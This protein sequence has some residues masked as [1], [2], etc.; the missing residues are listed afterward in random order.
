MSDLAPGFPSDILAAEPKLD[1]ELS[2]LAADPVEFAEIEAADGEGKKLRSFAILAYTGGPMKV[3][4]FFHPVIV[5]LSGVKAN[6]KKIP[7]L[8]HHDATRI[9]GHGEVTVSGNDIHISG[10][11]SAETDAAREVVTSSLNGFP[12]QASIGASP[13]ERL[14]LVREGQTTQVNGKT[15]KGPVLVA[16]KSTLKEVSFVPIGAD[17]KTSAKVAATAPKEQE[18][19]FNAWLQAKGFDP[20]TISEAQKTSLQA[21]YDAEKAGGKPGGSGGGDTAR[22]VNAGGT[23]AFDDIVASA[24]NERERKTKITNLVA[25]AIEDRPDMIDEIEALGSAAIEAKTDPQK[26]ELEMLRA[27]RHT[28]PSNVRATRDGEI[29]AQVIEAAICASAGLKDVDKH[30]NERTLE[31][32]DKHFRHGMGLQQLL[33]L[34][35][36]AHGVVLQSC[37][38]VEG[39]LR[40]AFGKSDI[41]ASGG[42][43][44]FSLSGIL[45]NVANKFV[46]QYFNSVES[47]WRSIAAIRTV[48]DFKQIS[49]YSL[50]GDLQYEE[51]GPTGEIKHGTLGEETYNNQAKSYA[52]MLGISRKD[53]INDDLGAFEQLLRLLGRG[54]ALKIN[55]VF[56]TAFLDNASFFTAARGN[57]DDGA[58]DTLLDITGLTNAETLFLN[59]TDPDGKPLGVSPSVLLTPTAL[60]AKAAQLMSSLELRNTTASTEY[61]TANPHAG[62]YTPVRSSYL[63]NASYS[64]SSAKAWYLL[65]NP[66]D[67]PVIEVC[68]LNGRDVPLVESADANFDT[69]G[70]QLRGVHDF[71]VAKQEYRAG[72]KMKGEA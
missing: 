32:K 71:G 52:K 27:T 29:S 6:A 53:I 23:T 64:G 18:M 58:A 68:L 45:S 37:R 38:D 60:S 2:I 61:G 66:M 42:F 70:I 49:S 24:R 31:A 62:K 47:A 10:V 44:S 69:L 65:A 28:G 1:G 39:T 46:V 21:M 34:A 33:I 72:V 22:Q 36:A 30:F 54:A 5:D 41:R 12:W 16:R 35:A 57:F 50:T 40:A 11:V 55:D 3:D 9:V 63:S 26:F 15:W 59:Q 4:G 14:E 13:T 67:L 43:S 56:W 51:V 48:T 19:D 17:S 25:K 20:D 8:Q 7:I